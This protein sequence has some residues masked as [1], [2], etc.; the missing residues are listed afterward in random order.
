MEEGAFKGREEKNK[1]G[2]KGKSFRKE[3]DKREKSRIERRRKWQRKGYFPR[4]KRPSQDERGR[5]CL[6]G[7][8]I[9]IRYNEV[10]LAWGPIPGA[11]P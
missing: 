9:I 11:G 3:L 5:W 10:L 7:F 8:G 2:K 1:K 4:W 6:V